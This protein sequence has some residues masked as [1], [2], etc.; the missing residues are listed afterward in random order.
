VATTFWRVTFKVRRPS[1]PPFRL[2]L[3]ALTGDNRRAAIR[4]GR[5]LIVKLYP[6]ARCKARHVTHD[7][8]SA[9]IHKVAP[10]ERPRSAAR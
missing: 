10:I 7:H 1:A 3:A 5:A 6:S 8:R 2:T 9:K 4:H